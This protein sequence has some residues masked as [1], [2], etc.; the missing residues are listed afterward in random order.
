MVGTAIL[1]L[2]LLHGDGVIKATKPDM[3]H[4]SHHPAIYLER[5][6]GLLLSARVGPG[7]PN[8]S[9]D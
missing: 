8:L 3:A 4:P 2:Y 5:R 1:L 7:S 6:K 9:L